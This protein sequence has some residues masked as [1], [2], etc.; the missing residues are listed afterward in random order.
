MLVGGKMN[1]PEVVKVCFFGPSGSGKS[2][3]AEISEGI[4]KRRN[5]RV[6]RVNVAQPLH[7]VQT[8]SYLRFDLD[9]TGQD[10]EL[11]QFLAHH[12]EAMLGP[13]FRN[14]VLKLE[15]KFSGTRLAIINS[16][17]R[18]NSYSY[19]R[20]LNFIFIRVLSD[21]DTIEKRLGKRGDITLAE[22]N[23]S[24][25][26]INLIRPDIILDNN[27]TIG[28]LETRIENL[29]ENTLSIAE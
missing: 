14:R 21:P 27:G 22:K 6:E 25:E 10:G 24:V 8:Y 5:F 15:S 19:L 4:F 7:D 29:F 3:C 12:F 9:N 23:K 20:D 11:L 26:Q 18:N 1:T 28:E 13:C 16:D 17:C 2:T